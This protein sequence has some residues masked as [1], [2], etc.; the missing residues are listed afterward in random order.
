[1]PNAEYGLS[2]GLCCRSSFGIWSFIRHSVILSFVILSYTLAMR[3]LL[4]NDD[5]ILA[6]GLAALRSA[7]QDLG[8]VTVVAPDSPQSAVGRS[9]T[10]HGPVVCKHVHVEGKF[11]GIGVTG[12]PVDCLKLAVR[13]LMPD[14]PDLVLS[15]LNAGANVGVNVFYSGTVAAA[16]EGALFG[17]PSVAFSLA[18]EGE[19]NFT[20]AAGYCRWVLDGLLK[21]HLK[22][23]ELVNVN[24]PP[25]TPEGPKGVKVVPQATVPI[26][27]SYIRQDGHNGSLMFTLSDVYAHG[28]HA[29]ESDVL[30]MN[31][32]YITVT[33]L[34]SDM[35]DPAG[36]AQ[37]AKLKW[38]PLKSDAG[39]PGRGDMT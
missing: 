30:A 31:D 23:G 22:A 29:G 34:R 1:M 37:L 39:T 18:G 4:T 32:G 2:P 19:L 10:L 21:S 25:L 38:P 26:T 12:R 33:A 24:I 7:V 20:R 3:I 16:A 36:M 17:I 11:W 13:E 15:G 35:T 14:K 27:E 28:Q 8:E 9:I 5:G 6:P